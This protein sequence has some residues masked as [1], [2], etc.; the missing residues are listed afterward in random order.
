MPPQVKFCG[1]TRP[2]AAA[3]AVRLGAA[4]VGVI[5]AGGPR[6][7]SPARAAEVLARVP[8]TVRRVGVV[9][10]QTP[11]ELR[12]LVDGAGLDVVQ[13]HGERTVDEVRAL[14]AAL[15]VPLWAVV[16]IAGADL[17]LDFEA[18]GAAA[19]AVLVDAAVPGM[20]GG[21]GVTV[22]WVALA[23]GLAARG[24]PRRLVLAGGL[25][26]ENVGQALAI[27]APDVVDVSSGVERAPGL[28][29]HARMAAFARAVATHPQ[30][31]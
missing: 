15:G 6:Q 31:A 5:F 21:S 10:G 24:R 25:R 12:R 18:R 30:T 4:Y 13:L 11:D 14:R 8:A 27:L 1:L 3:E 17:P 20:L 22:D 2:E 16:R 29:D 23:G 28:K 26:P 7:L 9:A 19:D